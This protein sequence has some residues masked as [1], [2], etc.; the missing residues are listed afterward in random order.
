MNKDQRRNYKTAPLSL[1]QNILN[2]FHAIQPALDPDRKKELT[3][4]PRGFFY[5]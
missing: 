2:N 5:K 1:Y 3:V 4:L